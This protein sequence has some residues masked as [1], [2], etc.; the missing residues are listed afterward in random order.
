[1]GQTGHPEGLAQILG[2]LHLGTAQHQSR[3]QTAALQAGQL[4]QAAPNPRRRSAIGVQARPITSILELVRRLQLPRAASRS[5]APGSSG[6][7]PADGRRSVPCTR[8][9]QPC[10]GSVGQGRRTS[11]VRPVTG[12]PSIHSTASRTEQ[13][14]PATGIALHPS[15]QL[16]ILRGS[17]N[18]MD[19]IQGL[20]EGAPQTRPRS[21]NSR[22]NPSA[23]LGTRRD[24]SRKNQAAA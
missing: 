5:A 13:D 12:R 9:R 15:D 17:R 24:R 21:S 11:S 1:M 20:G 19:R 6:C 7:R 16:H 22:K 4:L 3:Q 8:T 18:A 2:K 10:N 23:R 14:P